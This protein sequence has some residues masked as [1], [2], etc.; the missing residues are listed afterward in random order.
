MMNFFY[1]NIYASKYIKQIVN[2]EHTIKLQYTDLNIFFKVK[3]E[4][5]YQG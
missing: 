1:S 2:Y 4:L 5:A 3:E